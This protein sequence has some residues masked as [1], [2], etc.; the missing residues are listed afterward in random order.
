MKKKRFFPP[1]GSSYSKLFQDSSY[2]IFRADVSGRVIDLNPS[3]ARMFGYD[4]PDRCIYLDLGLNWNVSAASRGGGSG[5]EAFFEETGHGFIEKEFTR[6]DGTHF[7]A[8]VSLVLNTGYNGYLPHVEGIIEDISRGKEG[9]VSHPEQ[10]EPYRGVFENTGTATVV[11]D[12]STVISLVNDTFVSVFGYPR[13]QVEG[14]M[15]W[16][17]FIHPDD[18]AMMQS[19]HEE[20]RK[21][22]GNPPT[23]YECRALTRGGV[24]KQ[25][26]IKVRMI[27]NT[28]NSVASFMDITPRKEAETA[29][30]ESAARLR[31]FVNAFKGFI[32]TSTRE[33]V[34]DFMNKALVERTGYDATG[35]FCYSALHGFGSPCP[36]CRMDEVFGGKTISWEVKSPLD[37]HWY[38]CMSSPELRNGRVERQYSTL[39]DITDRKRREKTLLEHKA[40]LEKEN[41]YLKKAVGQTYR[42][43][44]IIG[45]SAAMQA[46]YKLIA[47]A[48][49]TSA[50]VI[51][52]GESGTGKELVA[53]AIHDLSDRKE[54]PF[55]PVNCSAIPEELIESEFFGYKKGAFSHAD[56]DKQ[57]F[58][59][60]ADKGTLFLDEIGDIGLKLQG[61]LLRAIDGGGY[62]PVGSTGVRQ[63]DFR[64]VGAT[65]KNLSQLVEQGLMRSDF[66]FRVHVL[67]IS[68][69][70][71]RERKEDLSL[72]IDYF[73]DEMPEPCYLPGN[74]L[75]KLYG[76]HWPGNVR[77]LRNVLNRYH[78]LKVLDL[79]EH[80]G[81]GKKTVDE[82][83]LLPGESTGETLRSMVERLEKRV[84]LDALKKNQ[85]HRTR[86]A[87]LLG[88]DRKT[89]GT[90]IKLYGLTRG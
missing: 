11:V 24:E 40:F 6:K 67:S 90:K 74:I 25:I 12:E 16:A 32:Y 52:H 7:T 37:A 71:L 62:C 45:K 5:L 49:A 87:S 38:Y 69:P 55:V 23:E 56:R 64:I 9:A 3:F 15:S 76:Y 75:E 50:S 57:G 83:A 88:I 48:G 82:T 81:N 8:R 80:P 77:E 29:L 46:V 34:I 73:C 42:F 10:G 70:P 36:W 72:L 33:Y 26:L 53:R 79:M 78:T 66:Y 13:E 4:H 51:V 58:L 2:G 21:K 41:L 18:L 39:I 60:A 1:R 17:D 43:G 86:V 20:R 28:G 65:N 22:N 63:S 84:I 30:A 85:W 19:Y 68:L 27:P 89:L 47:K 54:H 44:N 59:D 14:R 35:Q 31:S 61:K